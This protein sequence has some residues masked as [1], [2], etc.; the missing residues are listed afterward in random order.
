MMAIESKAMDR[1]RKV[2]EKFG[3]KYFTKNGALKRNTVIE[4]LDNYDKELVTEILK[5]EL[6]HE[7]YT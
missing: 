2:L 6:L 1:I 3:N 7:T 5:D 4:D